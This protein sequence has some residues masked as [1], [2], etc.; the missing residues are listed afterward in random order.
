MRT[1][2]EFIE[3]LKI[4]AE[5]ETDPALQLYKSLDLAEAVLKYHTSIIVADYLESLEGNISDTK[6]EGTR[7]LARGMVR[8]S[9]GLWALFTE[10]IYPLV[11]EKNR[12]I[13]NFG[14]YFEKELKE[15]TQFLVDERNDYQHGFSRSAEAYHKSTEKILKNVIQILENSPI[16]ECTFQTGDLLEGSSDTYEIVLVR[17]DGRELNLSPLLVLRKTDNDMR[18]YFFYELDTIV[19][20]KKIT[21]LNYV[22]SEKYEDTEDAFIREFKKVF[23]LKE[24][25]DGPPSKF[26]AR[27][28]ELIQNF[29]GRQVEETQVLDSFTQRESGAVL[30]LGVPGIGKSAF[31]AKV[32]TS[33]R[34]ELSERIDL[35]KHGRIPN[36]QTFVILEY[37]FRRNT[38]EVKLSEF[39]KFIGEELNQLFETKDIPIGNNL[40]EMEAKWEERIRKISE[41]LSSGK[42]KSTKKLI[43]VL[44]GIDEAEEDITRLWRGETY[45]RVFFFL[46]SRPVPRAEVIRARM[47]N[48]QEIDLQGLSLEDT[49]AF[50]LEINREKILSDKEETILKIVFQKSGGEIFDK[51]RSTEQIKGANPL[52]LRLFADGINKGLYSFENLESLPLGLSS[53]YDPILKELKTKENSETLF[54]ILY[55]ITLAKDY[56][57]RDTISYF[58]KMDRF[59]FDLLFSE[60]LELLMKNPQKEKG[61]KFQFFHESLRDHFREKNK[62]ELE[63]IQ[64]EYILPALED[65]E[66]IHILQHDPNTDEYFMKYTITHLLDGVGIDL[67]DDRFDKESEENLSYR[68]KA[69]KLILNP[70]F[71]TSQVESLGQYSVS[72]DDAVLV[73]NRIV[74]ELAGKPGTTR[75]LS[76]I[77][78]PKREGEK[79]RTTIFVEIVNYTGDL[80]H[81]ASTDIGIAW[82]WIEEG[83]VVQALERLSSIQDKQRLFDCYLFALWLLSLQPDGEENRAGLKL[84]LEE[85]EKWIPKAETGVVKW[86]DNFSVEF[87]ADVCQILLDRGQEIEEIFN[88][89]DDEEKKYMIHTCLGD[90]KIKNVKLKLNRI[91]IN[92]R[93]IQKNISKLRILARRIEDTDERISTLCSIGDSVS[94]L[95]D[96]ELARSIFQE[97]EKVSHLI[98]DSYD[99]SNSLI[100]I[101][102][103][104]SKLG[105]VELARSLYQEVIKLS[106]EIEDPYS[107]KH[108]NLLSSIINSMIKLRDTSFTLSIF[109]YLV[110]KLVSIKNTNSQRFALIEIAKLICIIGNHDIYSILF[111]VLVEVARGIDDSENRSRSLCSIGESVSKLGDAELSRS[112]FPM[113]VEVARGIE[114]SY[115]RSDALNSIGESVSK[116]GDV[117]FGLKLFQESLEVARGIEDS[118]SRSDALSSIGESLSKLGDVELAHNLFQESLEVARGIESSYSL[119]NRLHRLGESVSELNNVDLGNSLFPLLVEVAQGIED[120]NE[121][122]E[123]IGYLGESVNNLGDIKLVQTLFPVLIEMARAIE[124][125]KHRSEGISYIGK[126][127]IKLGDL[128][129][130]NSLFYEALEIALGTMRGDDRRKALET[131][132]NILWSIDEEDLWN[133]LLPVMLRLARNSDDL[134]YCNITLISIGENLY[135]LDN[136]ELSRSLFQEFLKRASTNVEIESKT[137]HFYTFATIG[138]SLNKIVEV[139]L[140]RSFFPLMIEI[141]RDIEDPYYC[142]SSLCSIGESLIK[143]EELALGKSLIWEA[144]EKAHDIESSRE[145]NKISDK[146]I[147]SISNLDALETE[148]HLLHR[149]EELTDKIKDFINRS[150][151]LNSIAESLCQK[152][153][154]EKGQSFFFKAIEA[155][156]NIKKPFSICDALRNIAISVIKIGDVNLGRSILPL[157]VKLASGIND[158]T[159]SA[160]NNS[161]EIL[162][163]SITKLKNI[164][165]Y[166]NLIPYLMDLSSSIENSRFRVDSLCS[167]GELISEYGNNTLSCSLLIE[168]VVLVREMRDFFDRYRL[169]IKIGDLIYKLGDMELGLKLVTALVEVV[170]G[171]EDFDHRSEVLSRIGESVCKLGD[172]ELGRNLFQEA[173][174]VAHDIKFSET[175]SYAFC[176]IGE[177]FSKIG[178]KHISC[179]LFEEALK[180]EDETDSEK[181]RILSHICESLSRIMY[182][183]LFFKFIPIIFKFCNNLQDF[184]HRKNVISAIAKTTAIYSS[185]NAYSCFESNLISHLEILDVV[186]AYTDEYRKINWIESKSPVLFPFYIRSFLWIPRESEFSKEGAYDIVRTMAKLGMVEEALEAFVTIPFTPPTKKDSENDEL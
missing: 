64:R 26:Q 120:T 175:R 179:S 91:E 149:A 132:D 10:R 135:K 170:R 50:L 182:F 54:L 147:K 178:E 140:I 161:I 142:S 73:L 79:F 119:S 70:D 107:Y 148:N 38:G 80:S 133:C 109:P 60:I 112:L 47:P 72:L 8:P 151:W 130:C 185:I 71:H 106:Q 166:N 134:D 74:Y 154:L 103:F 87:Y 52:Y 77:F 138:D 174:E 86:H 97:A 105:Y 163:Y 96:I 117:E 98:E 102:D 30:V 83:K 157:L 5:R 58:L 160:L 67:S 113:M 69:E 115:S 146:L 167:I 33:I 44:D 9:L 104:V 1:I 37:F 41:K 22:K 68:K 173:I 158:S 43:L 19:N 128:N 6:K 28:S 126:V 16:F 81:K 180:L 31:L 88:R 27:I 100:R 17:E 101:G 13:E 171:I 21:K 114:D 108:S 61:E 165:L 152:G 164:D 177:S 93:K 143:I 15:N 90:K 159:S 4:S 75:P 181:S 45:P 63:T 12:F 131:I 24:W 85:V 51:E 62:V 49:R 116:L 121:R 25:S 184:E 82:K 118:Y 145:F 123:A 137:D 56:V 2:P 110:E 168:A 172:L 65:W 42:G 20:T 186:Q 162:C 36:E 78:Q 144:V 7:I 169:L 23:K 11:L 111:P 48:T 14:D 18:V 95:G 141:A 156:H 122:S 153:E 3:F 94:I 40:Q 183:D 32:V 125:S 127:V 39:Y 57:S 35:N 29:Q 89:G 66:K 59:E 136:I 176:S 92:R 34:S 150:F 84:V 53:V 46:S 99:R 155:S 139:D 76:E 124:N 129:W 55:F